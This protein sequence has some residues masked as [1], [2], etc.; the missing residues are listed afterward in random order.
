VVNLA[1]MAVELTAF[2]YERLTKYTNAEDYNS[3]I[4]RCISYTIIITLEGNDTT[5]FLLQ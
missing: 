3:H 4:F 5:L 2:P 1:N